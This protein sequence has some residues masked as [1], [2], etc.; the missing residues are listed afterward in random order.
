MLVSLQPNLPPKLHHPR[1]CVGSRLCEEPSPQSSAMGSAQMGGCSRGCLCTPHPSLVASALG[2]AAR[3]CRF[4]STIHAGPDAPCR[5]RAAPGDVSPWLAQGLRGS[6]SPAGALRLQQRSPKDT[7]HHGARQ[8]QACGDVPAA[9]GRLPV[10]AMGP[11]RAA[12]PRGRVSI[13]TQQH[14]RELRSLAETPRL[15]PGTV[16][17]LEHGAGTALGLLPFP[18]HRVLRP[19]LLGPLPVHPQPL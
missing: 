5:G 2:G 4:S 10:L 18:P 15:Q 12:L 14:R 19:V 11:S 16:W 1:R 9:P 13:P 7:W 17:L 8:R 6:P 3:G